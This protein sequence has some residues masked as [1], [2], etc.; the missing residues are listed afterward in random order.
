MLR[1]ECVCWRFKAKKH[2]RLT[3]GLV[4]KLGIA[5]LETFY[6]NFSQPSHKS[7]AVPTAKEAEF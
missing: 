6:T 2:P 1:G 3:M 5:C 4:L 7:V